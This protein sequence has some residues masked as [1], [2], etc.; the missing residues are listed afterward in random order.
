MVMPDPVLL[1]DVKGFLEEE[2]GRR[3]Y[4]LALEVGSRGPCL[5]IGSYCGKSALYLGAACR[6]S[7]SVLFSVD[8]HRGSEEQQP[9]EE[10]FDPELWD[11]RSLSVDTLSVFRRTIA[12]A[13]L[14]AFVVPL[15]CS[16]V[17]AAR[18][19][20]TPLSLVFIDGGHAEETVRADYMGW[21]DHLIPGGYLLFHDVFPEPDRGG[22]APF[23]VYRQ[24][25]DDGRFVELSMT[26]SLGVLRRKGRSRK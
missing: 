15:V 23:A 18:V 16:S 14:E 11:P 8:H 22:Q 7:G 1:Q 6:E 26:E 10:Y 25:R 9:G 21:S 4:A 2:E 12:K 20:A 13:G 19:W 5:E 3:L 17:V 24:A